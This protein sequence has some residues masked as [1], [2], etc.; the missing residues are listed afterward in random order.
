M[1]A[2]KTLRQRGPILIEKQHEVIRLIVQ[3][4]GLNL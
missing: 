1:A 2:G 3:N 4:M